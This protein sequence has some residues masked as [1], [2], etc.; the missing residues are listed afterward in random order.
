MPKLIRD[1]AGEEPKAL[2]FSWSKNSGEFGRSPDDLLLFRV[3]DHRSSPLS[4]LMTFEILMTLSILI[5]VVLLNCSEPAVPASPHSDRR[6][7]G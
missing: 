6:S 5:F 1:E 7:N 4:G 2:R 3:E